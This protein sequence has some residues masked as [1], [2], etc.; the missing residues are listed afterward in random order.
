MRALSA[1]AEILAACY[2]CSVIAIQFYV[3][4]SISSLRVS[5]SN[6]PTASRE[7]ENC[8][9]MRHLAASPCPFLAVPEPRDQT[10]TY[11]QDV[12]QT[13]VRYD[14]GRWRVVRRRE[15]DHVIDANAALLASISWTLTEISTAMIKSVQSIILRTVLYYRPIIWYMVC[16][17]MINY[18]TWYMI[19]DMQ[20]MDLMCSREL[21]EHT[22]RTPLT[23]GTGGI[24]QSGCVPASAIPFISFLSSEWIEIF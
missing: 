6:L 9:P 11:W 1:V 3:S 14:P 12:S 13:T 23:I 8:V 21:T 20:C 24:K 17:Y 16:N 10:F 4:I 18:D 7:N 22:S 15:V 19:H 5:L 2:D